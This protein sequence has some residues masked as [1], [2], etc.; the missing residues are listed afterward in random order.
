DLVVE[1]W[2]DAACASEDPVKHQIQAVTKRPADAYDLSQLGAKV[3]RMPLYGLPMTCIEHGSV[4]DAKG[5]VDL[6]RLLT[7]ITDKLRESAA[8]RVAQGRSVIVYGGALHNDL[9]PR[10]PLD[11]L[12][13][14]HALAKHTSVLEI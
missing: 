6:L 1:A 2:F 7:M 10:W 13:Y 12:S 14:A 3:P 4:L 5:R 11:E 8:R 9:D